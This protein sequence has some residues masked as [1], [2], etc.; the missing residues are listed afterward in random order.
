MTEVQWGLA[1]PVYVT[2]LGE[3]SEM[4]Q[5][6][7]GLIINQSRANSA[8]LYIYIISDMVVNIFLKS[9]VQ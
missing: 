2:R 8:R 7:V 5:S 4:E 3:S 6:E 1:G 9:V